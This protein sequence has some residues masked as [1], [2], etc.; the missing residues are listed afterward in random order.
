[1]PTLTVV[2]DTPANIRRWADLLD[3]VTPERGLITSEI[4]PAFRATGPEITSGG[5]LLANL[6]RG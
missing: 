6:W 5:L 2:V 3:R 1:V 4:V